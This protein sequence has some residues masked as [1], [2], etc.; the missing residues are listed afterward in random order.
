M[1]DI[2][3]LFIY[4]SS[5]DK[6]Y[7]ENG[8]GKI[9]EIVINLFMVDGETLMFGIS[10]AFGDLDEHR[11]SDF[12]EDKNSF[13]SSVGYCTRYTEPFKILFEGF[14]Y[15]FQT[16]EE[17][18]EAERRDREIQEELSINDFKTFKL[19]QCVICLE[20]LSINDFKTFKLEQCV[21]CLEELS[22][23]GS[24][25]FKSNQCVI[26]LEELSINDFKTFKLE[27]CVICLEEL[28]INGSK[29][30]KS[31]QC[32]SCLEKENTILRIIE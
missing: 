9:Y 11:I 24:K 13:F 14:F 16:E 12:K 5:C 29:T 3:P 10:N 20:E 6:Y 18:L 4:I 26:C 28:S 27:Q 19:E 21:I 23:N 7:R 15:H 8:H 30:F 1:K 25:T 22:I 32:V 31:N 2:T 17:R